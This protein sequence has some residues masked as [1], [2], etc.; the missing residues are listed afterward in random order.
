MI[1]SR[2]L[3]NPL[4]DAIIRAAKE[5]GE[6]GRGKGELV[7][8]LKEL[9]REEPNLF[10]GLLKQVLTM[11]QAEPEDSEDFSNWTREQI[12]EELLR[13]G[14]ICPVENYEDDPI[15]RF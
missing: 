14:V 10:A 15:A 1:Q 11:P 4:R 5:L 7:G 12:I 13:R 9:A 3:K 6:N 2:G 8:Y